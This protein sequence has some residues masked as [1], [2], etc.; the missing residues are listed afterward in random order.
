MFFA[1]SDGET[2]SGVGGASTISA[3]EDFS[4]ADDSECSTSIPAIR[5]ASLLCKRRVRR[6]FAVVQ[7]RRVDVRMILAIRARGPYQFGVSKM[8]SWVS[9]NHTYVTIGL[10][11]RNSTFAFG[12][13]RTAIPA[14]FKS[15]N[16][17]LSNAKN[18][19]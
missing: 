5:I 15:R 14:L 1:P 17:T 11:Q 7:I 6:S 3:D 18:V 8:V 12:V 2:R 16:I 13:S 9:F 19:V 4:S 10:G